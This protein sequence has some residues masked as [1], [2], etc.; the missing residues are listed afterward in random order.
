M[1]NNFIDFLESDPPID[2]SDFTMY[3]LI[4]EIWERRKFYSYTDIRNIQKA[5]EV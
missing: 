3:E 4:K 5:A 2:G 1:E